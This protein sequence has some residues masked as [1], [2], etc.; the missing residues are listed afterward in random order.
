MLFKNVKLGT[1]KGIEEADILVEEGKVVKISKEISTIGK[2]TLD[3][4]EFL[5]IPGAIDGHTHF[6]SRFLGAKEVI[7]TADDYLSGSEV[8]LS[9]G[10]TT[11][12]NFIEGD[13]TQMKEEVELASSTSKADFGFHL[14][15]RG[16]T[17][18]E[19]IEKAFSMNIRSFKIFMAY[20]NMM[21]SDSEI[22]SIAEEVKRLGGVLA[23]HAENGDIIEYLKQRFNG[24]DALFHAMSRPPEVEEEAVNRFSVISYFTNVKSYVVHISSPNSLKIIDEWSRKGGKIKAETCPHYLVFDESMYKR[25]DGFRFI[26]SP[27]LRSKEARLELIRSLNKVYS[28]G[29]DYAGYLSKY[30]DSPSSYSEVPNGVASTEFLVPTIYS[31]AFRGF[32]DLSQAVKIT[33]TN[34]AELYGLERKGLEEGKDADLVFLKRE[35]Y[36]VKQWHGRMDHSIYEGVE[37]D[38]KVYRTYLRGEL[39]YEEGE[40]KGSKGTQ[41]PRI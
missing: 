29:S 17:K 41:S 15:V 20:K 37:Y 33:S 2:S 27:P 19:D 36:K 8:A 39:V 35:K 13:S 12:L 22:I 40:I 5:V 9:G 16:S 38:A 24:K 4:S 14:I 30:K 18:K 6:N 25:N 23:V 21:S 10:I 11:Y 3:S 31:L 1:P 32:I 34:P 28:V 7:P 26:M